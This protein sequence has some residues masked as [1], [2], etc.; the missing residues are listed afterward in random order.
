MKLKSSLVIFL[1]FILSFSNAYSQKKYQGLLWKISGNGLEKPSYMYGTMH[2][3][4]KIAFY[5][6]SPFYD[7]LKSTDK[8]ALEL[9][10]ELW[11]DEVLGGD[12]LSY[13]LRATSSMSKWMNFKDSWNEYEGTFKLDTNTRDNIKA[14]FKQ[15]P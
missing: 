13:T 4:N 8:V 6:G 1:A 7:A 5:L 9:E 10:P 3:S 11:F 14:L 15:S 12:F 2:V